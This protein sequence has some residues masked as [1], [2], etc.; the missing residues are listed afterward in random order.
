MSTAQAAA[1]AAAI[2][3]NGSRRT[4]IAFLPTLFVRRCRAGPGAARGQN[5]PDPST[6]RPIRPHRFYHFD[7]FRVPPSGARRYML[8]IYYYI[9]R[10]DRTR[11]INGN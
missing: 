5:C 8:N 11:F 7:T 3:L 2:H 9:V 6:T 1:S 10:S 4:Y